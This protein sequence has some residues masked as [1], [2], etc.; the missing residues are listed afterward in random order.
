V[1][2]ISATGLL[3]GGF[4]VLDREKRYS[5]GLIAHY[6]FYAMCYAIYCNYMPIYL[7]QLGFNN[8][9][10]GVVFSIGPLAAIIGQGFW[11]R[12]GD[13]VKY[14]NTVLYWLLGGCGAMMLI[15]PFS[16]GFLNI[17]VVNIIYT[18]F[19]ASL[20][21]ISDAIA[22][23]YTQRTKVRYGVIRLAGTLG[24]AFMSVAAGI[25]L[26]RNVGRMFW[27]CCF[28]N[29]AALF[30]LPSLPKIHRGH[31]ARKAHP[32]GV[33]FKNRT[34]MM[35]LL[36]AMMIYSTVGFYGSFYSIY[37][38]S[39]GGNSFLLGWA[40]FIACLSELP[41]LL[42]S[43]KI[44]NRFK[45]EQLLLLA[46]C[47][48]TVRWFLTGIMTGIGAQMILQFF[49]GMIYIVMMVSVAI[50]ISQNAPAGLKASGLALNAICADGI[51]KV[52]G[53]LMGGWLSDFLNMQAVFIFNGVIALAAVI[54]FGTVLFWQ[55]RGDSHHIESFR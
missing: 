3:R 10:I 55:R 42:F 46:G 35:Y 8:M 30:I 43:T 22:L 17:V 41:F 29:V 5:V 34:L 15:M 6:W 4:F 16:H 21:P 40:Y 44:I 7:R 9:R 49:H 33:L 2:P 18:F 31:E 48:A 26:K 13:R 11:G 25:L 28:F 19:Q 37:F 50:Y 27:F 32:P 38:T 1:G 23:E 52:I 45:I 24:Y 39:R 12:V 36:Y 20:N 47:A 51:S 53:S 14:L 54:L